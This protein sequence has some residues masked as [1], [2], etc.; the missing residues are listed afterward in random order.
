MQF[1]QFFEWSMHNPSP[2]ITNIC[3]LN[4]IFLHTHTRSY[5]RVKKQ[6]HNEISNDVPQEHIQRTVIHDG[7]E[8]ESTGTVT[9]LW[10]V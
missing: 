4:L 1:V 5:M 10:N 2:F 6:Q 3:D 7:L 9:D 8:F